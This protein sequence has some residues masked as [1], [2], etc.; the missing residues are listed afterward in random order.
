MRVLKNRVILGGIAAC[1]LL[2]MTQAIPA[3]AKGGR[4]P[5]AQGIVQ[6]RPASK[7]GQWIIGGRAFVATAATQLDQAEGALTVGACAKVTYRVVNGAA[8]AIEIDSEPAGD[9]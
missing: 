6:A 9:C 2:L 3:E 7:A 1:A 5:R 4:Q 8:R